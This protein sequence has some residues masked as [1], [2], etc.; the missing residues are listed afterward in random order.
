MSQLHNPGGC[1]VTGVGV[2]CQGARTM[3]ALVEG[4]ARRDCVMGKRWPCAEVPRK[5]ED[6]CD[7]CV[8]RRIIQ[9]VRR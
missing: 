5:P 7:P 2:D 6:W 8:A 1:C 9:E 4:L 3:L